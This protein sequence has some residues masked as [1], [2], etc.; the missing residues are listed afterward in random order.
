MASSISWGGTIKGMV[1][2]TG[3]KVEKKKLKVTIDNYICGKYKDDESLLLSPTK[4][5]RNAVVSLQL[6]PVTKEA[7]SQP[8]MVKEMDQKQCTYVPHIL[9]VPVGGTVKFL[10]S[11][12]LLHNIKSKSG[13]P[14]FNRAQPKGRALSIKFT[15][16][17]FVRV[18]CD[19]HSWMHAW[20]VVADHPFYAITDDEGKFLL[21]NVPPGKYTLRVW[22]ESL[23]V[24]D[25]EVVV[26]DKGTT[27]VTLVMDD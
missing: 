26:T 18:D 3:S 1:R 19:L 17:G 27:T 12:R 11:D 7:T 23:G 22:Q 16:P 8:P 20:V 6:S 2:Y 4:G 24:V 9:L 15:T 5:I 14:Q 10:N 21:G 13:H 25:K